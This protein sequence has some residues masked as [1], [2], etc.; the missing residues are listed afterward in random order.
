MT[1]KTKQTKKRKKQ[2]IRFC[3]NFFQ[4][5][6]YFFTLFTDSFL[7]W[8]NPQLTTSSGSSAASCALCVALKF[9]Y[10]H[11]LKIGRNHNVRYLLFIIIIILGNI[12][13]TSHDFNQYCTQM[14]LLSKLH[15][16]P[17][18]FID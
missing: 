15:I 17:L 2:L 13:Q 12:A 5:K 10:T 3:N 11:S 16:L 4:L 18:L 1:Y 9:P 6:F 14:Q 8:S 7:T